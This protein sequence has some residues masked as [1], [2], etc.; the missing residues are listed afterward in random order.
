M[1]ASGNHGSQRA[2]A[3]TILELMVVLAISGV[4]AAIA[5]PVFH[6]YQMR[7]KTSEVASNLAALRVLE[8]S[9][10]SAHDRFLAAPAEPPVIPGST[11]T[12]FTPNAEFTAL[13]FHPEGRVYFSYGVAVTADGTGYTVDAAA[14]IDGDGFPQLWGFAKPDPSGAVVAGQVGCAVAVLDE[15]VGPCGSSHGRSVF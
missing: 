7:S 6:T 15:D 11:S 13:G 2:S 12:V 10:A 9:Y 4:L 5:I 8:E 1:S 3:F 14:D